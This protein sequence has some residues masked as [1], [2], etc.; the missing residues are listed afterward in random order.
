M[1]SVRSDC[2][3][4]HFS[5]F[6]VTGNIEVEKM[7][8]INDPRDR[9]ET[10]EERAR[11]LRRQRQRREARRRRRRRIMLIRMAAAVTAIV[12]IILLVVLIV[13]K[14][15]KHAEKVETEKDNAKL[16]EEI[17]METVDTQEILHLSFLSLIAEP[18][19][20]FG[21]ENEQEVSVLDQ[22]R[23]TVDEFHQIL[24]QLYD[25]GYV[26]V[27][28]TDLAEAG[29]DGIMMG[30][31]LKLPQGKKPLILSQQNVSYDLE[32]TGMGLASR[33]VLDEN[34]K[35]VSEKILSDGTAVTGAYD[36]VPCVD[37]FV[38]EHPDFSHDGAKGILGI[39]GY[40]GLLGYRTEDMLASSEGNK[41]ASKYG[42]FDTAAEKEAVKPVI[43]ALKEDGWEFAC[44]GYGTINYASDPDQIKA[45]VQQWKTGVG[46]LLGEVNILFYPSGTDV[47]DTNV[48]AS[49]NEKYS[50]LKSEGFRY[51]SAMDIGSSRTQ[52]TEEYFRCNYKNLDGYRMYQ[53][54]YMNARRFAGV[55]DFS[56]VYDQNRPSVPETQ[57]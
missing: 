50:F 47:G 53:D 45:D 2:S 3:C 29:E 42:V 56:S 43:A 28:L 17:P 11:R 33:L 54:L 24:Q 52:T 30:K 27:K 21:L 13:G 6:S 5:P 14:V 46:Q 25:R 20:A 55:L 39:T 57:E 49:D 37:A 1:E 48:Y 12:L 8:E 4:R 41:Y 34:G 23:L 16:Q 18:D 36:I 26:L 38:E 10:A 35:P 31:E 44:N 32:Y 22:S 15:R 19:V 40:N 7:S 51:F 9:Q